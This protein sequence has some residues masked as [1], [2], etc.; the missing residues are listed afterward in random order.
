MLFL[1]LAELL[2]CNT[3]LFF[4]HQAL[5]LQTS[6]F[7]GFLSGELLRLC[8]LSGFFSKP[9]QFLLTGKFFG[10]QSFLGFSSEALFFLLLE[11]LD[12][13]FFL[14]LPLLLV[15]D[16]LSFGLFPF[17]FCKACCFDVVFPFLLGFECSI[18]D[19]KD[20]SFLLLSL[21]GGFCHLLVED[22]L[23]HIDIKGQIIQN[24]EECSFNDLWRNDLSL[25]LRLIFSLATDMVLQERI[26]QNHSGVK[27]CQILVTGDL[28]GLCHLDI[29]TG[30]SVGF[31]EIPKSLCLFEIGVFLKNV[32]SHNGR[33]DKGGAGQCLDKRRIL[34]II[35][36]LLNSLDSLEFTQL[37]GVNI[38]QVGIHFKARRINGHL[39]GAFNIFFADCEIVLK[40]YGCD[41]VTADT[42]VDGLESLADEILQVNK[43][44]IDETI[45]VGLK[46]LFFEDVEDPVRGNRI[47]FYL[48]DHVGV[49]CQMAD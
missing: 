23:D 37:L 32:G 26:V 48:C 18:D 40:Q 5:F 7:S 36:D 19:R 39:E 20:L 4:F 25:L 28:I 35:E 2:F 21:L 17:Q 11:Q 24:I 34:E 41:I 30:F 38:Q 33:T 45:L 12:T 1:L 8:L 9:L 44:G 16:P 49:L 31:D 47:I 13:E 27:V 43:Q 29:K 6:L 46:T 10:F 14:T 15:A 3:L 42:V 22:L